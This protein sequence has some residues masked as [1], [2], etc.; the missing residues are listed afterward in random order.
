VRW[1]APALEGAA[2][3]RAATIA[4]TARITRSA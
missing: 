4:A 2:S 3:A 1:A